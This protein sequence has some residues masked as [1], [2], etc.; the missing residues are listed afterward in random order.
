MTW[1]ADGSGAITVTVLG[2]TGSIGRQA[3]DVLATHPER[4]RVAGLAAGSNAELLIAQAKE[5]RPRR[6]AL[7]DAAAAAQVRDAFG[8][9]IEVLSGQDAAAALAAGGDDGPADIVLNGMVGSRGLLPTLAALKA[10]S[11]VALANKESLIVGG[12]LVMSAVQR[13]DQLVPVDSE[14]SAL[15]QCLRAGRE[16]E[17]ERLILTASGGPF[18]GRSR[19]ELGSVTVDDALSHPTWNMGA[20]ITVDSATLANK[21]LEVIEAH[22]LFGIPYERIEVVVHPQSIVHGM[23]EFRDGATIAKLSPPDMRLPIQLA[24]GWPERLDSA[25][26]QMDWRSPVN[27]Q[28]EPVD[29][30]TFPMIRIARAAGLQGGT[31]PGVFNAADEEAVSAFLDRRIDFLGIPA[32]VEAVLEEHQPE[33]GTDLETV[34]AAEQWARWRA[35]AR[36]SE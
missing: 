31:A 21:G 1:A 17:V 28:F 7:A 15:A 24:L 30:E 23:V 22:V 35:R 19:E 12:E 27:L 2:S 34:L 5:H 10:G 36:L 26:A 3:L 9:D 18:R 20:R 11:R 8:G 29:A 25:V 32:I 14:H 33:A 6:V 4:F 13:P 16:H